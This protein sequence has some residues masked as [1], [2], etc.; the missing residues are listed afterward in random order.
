MNLW[1]ND[2]KEKSFEFFQKNEKKDIP[3][4]LL[5]GHNIAIYVTSAKNGRI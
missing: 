5:L 1:Y 4:R 2:N 3:S